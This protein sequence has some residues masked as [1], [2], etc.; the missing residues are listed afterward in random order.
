MCLKP[1]ITHA[2]MVTRVTTHFHFK[3]TYTYVHTHTG[4][5]SV[6]LISWIR[7][8]RRLLLMSNISIWCCNTLVVYKQLLGTKR[9]KADR[10]DFVKSFEADILNGMWGFFDLYRRNMQ[11][12]C[13]GSHTTPLTVAYSFLFFP[14]W[15]DKRRNK[16]QSSTSGYTTLLFFLSF[17]SFSPSL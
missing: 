8:S 9:E 14:G 12:I 16:E 13:G 6:W 11:R 15:Q 4:Q 7:G 2:N 10:P 3:H 17:L 5:L 1:C